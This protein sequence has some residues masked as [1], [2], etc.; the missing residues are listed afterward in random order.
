MPAKPTFSPQPRRGKHLTL[1]PI[2]GDPNVDRGPLHSF[3]ATTLPV[4]SREGHGSDMPVRV[5]L[6]PCFGSSKRPKMELIW[7]PALARGPLWKNTHSIER[8]ASSEIV[9]G[10]TGKPFCQELTINLAG[11]GGKLEYMSTDDI[12]LF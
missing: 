12:T 3:A 7:E 4:A 8:N 2:S 9:P 1:L 10:Q 11:L 5:K 6:P